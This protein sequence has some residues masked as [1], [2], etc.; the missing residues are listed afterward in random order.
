M[1]CR[2][3]YRWPLDVPLRNAGCPACR[4]VLKRVCIRWKG[5]ARREFPLFNVTN[6]DVELH[7]MKRRSRPE[8]KSV[9]DLLQPKVGPG[10]D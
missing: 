5:E 9:A 4:R 7:P 3:T 10:T 8:E 6:S 1:E 2:W